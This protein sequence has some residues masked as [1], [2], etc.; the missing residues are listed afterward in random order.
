MPDD[1]SASFSAGVSATW[2]PKDGYVSREFAELERERLWPRVW[3]MACRVEEL[4]RVGSFV[5]YDILDDSIIVIRTSESEIRAYNNACL[6]RGRRL[7]EGC[8]RKAQLMC[9]FHGWRWN[10]DGSCAEVV[11][12]VDW[13]GALDLADL[14]LPEFKVGLWG[15]FV[16]V[17]MDPD[18][19]PLETFLE[20]M[21]GYMA[22]FEL[23]K[24]RYRWHVTL[25]ID[26][27]WKACQEAFEEGYHISATHPQLEPFLDSRS[28]TDAEGRHGVLRGRPLDQH[29]LGYHRPQNSDEVDNRLAAFENVRQMA[30]DVQAMYNERDVQAAAKVFSALPEGAGRAEVYG[31]TFGFVREA[32]IASG[33]G[34][35]DMTMEQARAAGSVWVTFPNLISVFSPTG[36]IWYRT[37]PLPDNNPDRCAIEMFAL[38]RYTPGAEPK[39]EKKHFSDWRDF[40]DLPPFLIDDFQNIPEVHRGMKTRG[41][42][43]A[44]PNPVQERTV[45]NFHR[46]LHDFIGV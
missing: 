39:V 45:S 38:E 10:L 23:E 44:R 2:I 25:E 30:R 7:T 32:A 37:S 8:G 28:P 40:K 1:V 11:D 5:T 27:N 9:R 13:G 22:P 17:N 16:F 15:G 14:R 18:C 36:G 31:A 46:A 20:P 41:F 3:Q 34:Y 29:V 21:A 43:G 19:E 12:Q 24:Q 4:D 26:A 35:P 33:A 42:K 6:H